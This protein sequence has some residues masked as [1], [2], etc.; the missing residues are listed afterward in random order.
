MNLLSKY[1]QTRRQRG[2]RANDRARLELPW[3]G[4]SGLFD[5]VG[6]KGSRDEEKE[7]GR[8][9]GRKESRREEEEDGKDYWKIGRDKED[10][11]VAAATATDFQCLKL[12]AFRQS[13]KDEN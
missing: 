6:T 10:D 8:G 4:K 13:S 12:L 9:W 2:D 7:K 1:P 3:L 11:S 5:L